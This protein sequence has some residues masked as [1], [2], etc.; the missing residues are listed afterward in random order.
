LALDQHGL[1]KKMRLEAVIWDMDGTLCDSAALHYEA[2]H[3]TMTAQGIEYTQEMFVTGFGRN[4]FE[5]LAEQ[6]PHFSPVRMNQVSLEKEVAYRRLLATGALTLL[7]GVEPWLQ[8]FQELGISQVIGSSAPM[9]NIVDMVHVLGIAD[10][11]HAIL[12]GYR[13]PRGK[14]DPLLFLRCADAVEAPRDACL[15]IEDSIH[16]I[17]AAY[18]AGM[19]C[20]AVGPV[21]Q[22]EAI[23]PYIRENWPPCRAV[24]TLAELSI[25]AIFAWYT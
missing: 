9:A 1:E 3:A 22:T 19:P 12:S 14:P 11:F 2:W 21:T 23:E 18:R 8:H 6:A 25:E 4:N 20:V 24:K 10:C 16:G 7:P 5:I 17:E 15:V 13:L